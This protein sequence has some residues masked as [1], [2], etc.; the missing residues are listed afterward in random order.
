MI[1]EVSKR[2]FIRHKQ[3]IQQFADTFVLDLLILC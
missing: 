3:M 1:K 2:I